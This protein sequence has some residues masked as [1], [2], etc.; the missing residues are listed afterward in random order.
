MSINAINSLL[1]NG[2]INEDTR[3]AINEA[4]E[5]QLAEA[6]E[7]VRSELREEFARRYDH[8]KNTMVVALD[9][10][11][12]EAL[13]E[14]LADFTQEKQE[15]KEDRIKFKKFVRESSNKFNQFMVNKL[16][17][18]IKQLR[19][20]R[21]VQNEGF[22]TLEKFVAEQLSS[23]IN[24]LENERQALAED[25]IKFKKF[26]RESTEKF[27]SFMVEKLSEEIKQI[28]NDRKV[29]TVGFKN[30]EKFVFEQLSTEIGHFAKDRQIVEETK[31]QLVI[32]AK[33][34]MSEMQK[35]FVSK[36]AKLVKEAVTKSLE[37]ELTQLNEDIKVARENM[38]GRR[39]FEAFAGEFTATHLNENKEIAKLSSLV[40]AKN[41][42]LEEAKA[43]AVKAS[44]LVEAKDR[45]VKIIRESAQRTSTIAEL[46]KP[47]SKDKANVMSELLEGVQ[48]NKLRSV[49]DKYLPS[50][51]NETKSTDKPKVTVLNETR[52]V[53]S[54]DK[55]AKP[56]VQYES[57]N[58]FEIKRLAGLK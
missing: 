26:V 16:A 56:N 29:Q 41:R 17:E 3:S 55:T 28:R 35:A 57:D 42:Q 8:D 53:V 33:Q 2:T 27:N 15:L 32:G 14:E 25:R 5:S 47:L 30:L 9:T 11:V 40:K 19:N 7:T 52:K 51:L 46:L 23:E 58:V 43:I 37:S 34:K 38:F 24:E 18:E 4:W 44:K 12:T 45:E 10:M 36:S 6:R 39:L 50:V 49:Y 1:D 21:K 48:T 13:Q 22:K 31:V 54:G 20:D